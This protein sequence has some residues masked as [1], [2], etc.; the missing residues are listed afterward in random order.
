MDVSCYGLYENDLNAALHQHLRA[1]GGSTF[2][3]YDVC[4]TACKVYSQTLT[5]INIQSAFKKCEMFP[6][7]D[8]LV[9]D[10]D[11]TPSLTFE[12][13]HHP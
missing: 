13:N 7:N 5:T 2:T 6:L 11:I 10:S 1:S 8:K 12:H 4:K 9:T 3:R